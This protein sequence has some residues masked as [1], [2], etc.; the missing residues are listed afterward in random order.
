MLKNLKYVYFEYLLLGI[1]EKRKVRKYHQK[2][3]L[4][5][6][7]KTIFTKKNLKGIVLLSKKKSK[8]KIVFILLFNTRLFKTCQLS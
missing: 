2:W 5:I 7:S 4:N 6:K 8:N 3:K 1:P